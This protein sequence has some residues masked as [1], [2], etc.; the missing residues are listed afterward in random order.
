LE[1]DGKFFVEG[2]HGILVEAIGQPEY[3]GRVR[4][5]GQGVG[6][7]L[8]FGVSERQSSSSN[9]ESETQMK[10]KIC[11]ELMEEMRKETD[12]MR[13]EM[14]EENDRMRQEFLSQQLCAEPIQP[15]VSPTPKSTNG[16]CAAPTTS[17]DDI[18]GQTRECELLVTGD[19]LPRVVALGKVYEESTTLHNVPLSPDVVKVTVEKV[20]VYIELLIPRYKF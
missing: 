7:K 2:R 16:S 6:I 12:L 20:R 3:C 15:F 8:Y 14:R 11:D 17:G 1:S 18:I 9:K 19:K 5:A 10:T 4:A 13:L